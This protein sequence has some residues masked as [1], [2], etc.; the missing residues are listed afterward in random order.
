MP[1]LQ[2]VNHRADTFRQ[3]DA[4]KVQQED[5]N[6]LEQ[7]DSDADEEQRDACDEP[8]GAGRHR[9]LEQAQPLALPP[10]TASGARLGARLGGPSAEIPVD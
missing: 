3:R 5:D 7:H 4:G 8:E 1:A 9:D 6:S 2:P 10:L